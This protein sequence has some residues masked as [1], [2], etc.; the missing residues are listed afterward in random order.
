MKNILPRDE[1]VWLLVA[2]SA[3]AE[4]GGKMSLFGFY[5][6]ERIQIQDSIALPSALPLV[7]VFLLREGVGRFL[8]TFQIR[9]PNGELVH[10]EN[11]APVM[12][13]S[14]RDNHGVAVTLAPFQI[15][16]LGSYKLT[17]T[18][19]GKRYKRT[20]TVESDALSLPTKH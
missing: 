10:S 18:L 20:F 6:T 3:R 7:F 13:P 16:S 12:K 2:D 11:L 4:A 14:A 8:A 9:D 19:D 1:N 5:G 17:L 15:P